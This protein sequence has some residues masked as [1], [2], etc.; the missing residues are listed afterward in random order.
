[1]KLIFEAFVDNKFQAVL[2]ADMIVI[3]SPLS[4]SRD[5]TMISIICFSKKNAV[6]SL[7]V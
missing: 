4:V 6:S 3:H 7:P 5:G 2:D 1:M